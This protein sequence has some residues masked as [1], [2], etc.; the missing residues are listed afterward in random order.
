MH[1]AYPWGAQRL[2]GTAAAVLLLTTLGATLHKRRRRRK[3]KRSASL[4]G[5]IRDGA[6]SLPKEF[7]MA[8]SPRTH[9]FTY[10][11]LDEATEGFSDARELGVGGFGTVYKGTYAQLITLF[12]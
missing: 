5:L 8:G 2:S 12:S 11:V 1:D 10:E 6:A 7:C 9:I 4:E 3:R